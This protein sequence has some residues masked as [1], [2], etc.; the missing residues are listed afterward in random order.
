MC[1][2]NG[3]RFTNEIS[4]D[5]FQIMKFKERRI[6]KCMHRKPRNNAQPRRLKEMGVARINARS[7]AVGRKPKPRSRFLTGPDP[8][9]LSNARFTMTIRISYG[10]FE[11]SPLGFETQ[12]LLTVVPCKNHPCQCPEKKAISLT[13]SG[14]R[15]GQNQ[16]DKC[17]PA[18]KNRDWITLRHRV[19]FDQPVA[20]IQSTQ[21]KGK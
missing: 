19:Q 1:F 18:Q 15:N 8:S 21:R 20:P 10:C 12:F 9:G 6:R 16:K 7:S 13:D 4:I 14:P 2:Q 3:E 5:S 11:F 17:E